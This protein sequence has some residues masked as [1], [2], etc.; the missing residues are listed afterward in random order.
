M[1]QPTILVVEDDAAVRRGVVDALRFSG[2]ET[3]EAANG[4]DGIEMALHSHYQLML[5]DLVMPHASGFDVLQAL[6]KSRPG[7]PVIV[8]SAK[9]EEADRVKGLAMG[10]DDYV[11]KPFSVKELLAR[12][13]AVLRRTCERK[14]PSASYSNAAINIDFSRKTFVIN[15]VESALSD[16]ECD[17]LRYLIGSTG[18]VVSREEILR[19]V[20]HL[21]G[22]AMETR[23]VDM[24]V[25][26]LRDKLC[27]QDATMIVTVRGKGYRWSSP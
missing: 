6:K 13:D 2:Y 9:G 12:V 18:R 17:L 7:Q 27:D 10:A 19:H 22:Q 24:H 23:T 11:V 15:H 4:R 16:R 21:N 25:A 5:L 26:N 1:N 3:I 8:L 20:W 14:S